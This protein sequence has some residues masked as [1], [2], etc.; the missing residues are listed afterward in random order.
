MKAVIGSFVGA[1]SVTLIAAGCAGI[2]K[3]VL[4][5]AAFDSLLAF[6][7]FTMAFTAILTTT[8]VTE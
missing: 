8:K 1:L 7:V 6:I 5:E 2:I 4:G 3:H